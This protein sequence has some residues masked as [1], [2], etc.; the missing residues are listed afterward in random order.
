MPHRSQ[1]RGQL[2][3]KGKPSSVFP[4]SPATD[5]GAGT[6]DRNSL[7]SRQCAVN[8]SSDG[9]DG[10]LWANQATCR[11]P[12]GIMD[13]I[14]GRFVLRPAVQKAPDLRASRSSDSQLHSRQSPKRH[15]L[16]TPPPHCGGMTVRCRAATLNWQKKSLTKV[17]IVEGQH[18]ALPIW[19]ARLQLP[20]EI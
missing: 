18:S 2:R 12:C 6:F 15:I 19:L 20:K 16:A 3:I 9:I 4:F 10:P 7:T 1:L 13:C 8:E 17:G 5:V 11:H 14:H